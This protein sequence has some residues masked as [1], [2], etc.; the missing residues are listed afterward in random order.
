LAFANYGSNIREIF[1]MSNT[2]KANIVLL[3]LLIGWKLLV[4]PIY[5]IVCLEAK[6]TKIFILNNRKSIY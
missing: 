2:D 1:G 4:F 3:L 5:H 6:P